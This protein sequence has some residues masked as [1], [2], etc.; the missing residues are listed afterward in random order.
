MLKLNK[1]ARVKWSAG[2]A[3]LMLVLTSS[4][5]GTAQSGEGQ[6]IF[7]YTSN[8]I[9]EGQPLEVTVGLTSGGTN[10]TIYSS[11]LGAVY[12]QGHV[13]A[14]VTTVAANTDVSGLANG[15]PVTVYAET[16]GSTVVAAET[17]VSRNTQN[18]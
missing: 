9:V 10:V 4:L 6:P 1:T 8:A 5:V 16:D 14:D 17:Y 15:T 7:E 2:F 12:Y 13:E 3:A 11:P 18:P